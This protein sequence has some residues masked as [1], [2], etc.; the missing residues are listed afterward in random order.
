[1][2]HDAYEVQY[3]LFGPDHALGVAPTY[4]E[5]ISLAAL[6][7]IVRNDDPTPSSTIVSHIDPDREQVNPYVFDALSDLLQ[8]AREGRLI[9]F[10]LCGMLRDGT[11]MISTAGNVMKWSITHLGN[12]EYASKRFYERIRTEEEVQAHDSGDGA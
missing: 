8:V 10:T 3:E 5:P 2:S 9:G 12:L 6:R 7:L 11:S 4:D 1:M